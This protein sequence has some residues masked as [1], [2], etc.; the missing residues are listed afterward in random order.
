MGLVWSGSERYRIHLAVVRGVMSAVLPPESDP[1]AETLAS[2]VLDARGKLLRPLLVL[3]GARAQAEAM[4]RQELAELAPPSIGEDEAYAAGRALG[5]AP[6]NESVLVDHAAGAILFP[7]RV[8]LLAAALELLHTAT[9]VHD[10]IIDRAEKRRGL[11]TLHSIGGYRRAILAGDYLFTTSLMLTGPWLTGF[12][13][14]DAGRALQLLC[15]G[16]MLQARAQDK[17]K[18]SPRLYRRQIAGKTA[19]LFVLAARGGA[20]LMADALGAAAPSPSTPQGEIPGL[21]QVPH[22]LGLYAYGLGMAFQINDDIL[23]YTPGAAS[24]KSA[25][26]DY[27]QGL[28]TLPLLHGLGKDHDGKLKAFMKRYPPGKKELSKGRETQLTKLLEERGA[29]SGA[30]AEAQAYLAS[31]RRQLVG[32]EPM[33][34][35]MADL[36]ALAVKLLPI[37]T[38]EARER[39]V[40]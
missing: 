28:L 12:Q 38:S 32:T 6:N 5:A 20:T 10:D 29:I 23:D 39:T 40:G 16:E 22:Q 14:A 33:V 36:D 8:Y 37:L 24:G 34:A 18:P 2:L 21:G 15:R 4:G 19:M 1:F 26:R 30:R 27:N 3:L 11:P 35:T 25:F 17:Q 7:G 31:G 13:H 9:L